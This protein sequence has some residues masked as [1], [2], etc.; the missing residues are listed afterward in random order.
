ML[1]RDLGKEERALHK[2]FRE[3]CFSEMH[4]RRGSVRRRFGL[5]SDVHETWTP[6]P[7]LEAG[8]KRAV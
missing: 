2:G 4:E 6:S 8:L 3:T 7:A 1:A 5:F